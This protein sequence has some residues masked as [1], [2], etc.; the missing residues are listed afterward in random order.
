[1]KTIQYAI[2]LHTGLTV[3]RVGSELAF[4]VLDYDKMLPENN[5]ETAYH[6]EKTHIIWNCLKWTRKIPV[7]I[8]NC[9][10]R[11]WGFKELTC[12]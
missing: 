2:D 3:S 6:L 4:F 5:F 1:M 8:K 10:R 11:F 7:D 12:K 9:H